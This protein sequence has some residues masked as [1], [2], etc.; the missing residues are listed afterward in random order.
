M[1]LSAIN[2]KNIKN[3]SINFINK[4]RREKVL[5]IS[6]IIISTL[7]GIFPKQLVIDLGL[8]YSN[9]LAL[10]FGLVY[11]TLYLYKLCYKDFHTF[12]L[13]SF[14]F[15]T[16]LGFIIFKVVVYFK[17]GPLL[18]AVMWGLFICPDFIVQI[19]SYILDNY[20]GILKDIKPCYI[21]PGELGD[22]YV[23]THEEI[24]SYFRNNDRTVPNEYMG[25]HDG[26]TDYPNF[27]KS[28]NYPY[29]RDVQDVASDRFNLDSFNKNY[30]YFG[31]TIEG[32]PD[33]S[34]FQAI[35]ARAD[36]FAGENDRMIKSRT[37]Y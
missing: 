17:G 12:S 31:G 7:H 26:L 6:T 36:P 19:F 24:R 27:T 14:T 11:S 23:P 30:G 35:D 37:P 1:I 2:K 8:Q 32:D 21:L 28:Y 25:V 18:L 33:F 34:K 16:F 15:R 3:L 4:I 29:C 5:I 9:I 20:V 10:Y 22:D 13:K